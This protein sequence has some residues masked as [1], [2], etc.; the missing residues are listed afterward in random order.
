MDY[1]TYDS[2]DAV[3]ATRLK[4]LRDSPLHYRDHVD[5]DSASRGMLRAIHAAVLE[6]ET[7]RRDFVV[8]DG[9][10]AGKAF[11]AFAACNEDATILNVREHAQV[12][13]VAAGILRHDLARELLAAPGRSEVVLR[14]DDPTTGI[15][16]KARLD[17]YADDGTLIDLKGYGTSDPRLI[18]RHVA[19][20]G[21]HIQLAHY[22]AGLEA[23]GMPH[24][25]TLVISYE[26]SPPFDVAI[27]EL[28]AD[29]ALKVGRDERD[30]LLGLLAECQAANHWPGRCPDIVP[31]D[32]PD[33]LM[34]EMEAD[35]E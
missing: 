5:K 16:C 32:L 20:L 33:Y 13:G 19:K 6:P 24:R 17:R 4:L 27:V 21:A 7:F 35:D 25:R 2:L 18:G 23:L 29:D 31:L 10:R 1:D 26:T 3:R 8:Y 22:V 15:P 34:P 12:G 30:R 9:R 28:L 11:E 14:W